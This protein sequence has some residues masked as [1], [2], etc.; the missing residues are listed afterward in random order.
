[1]A[2]AAP[3]QVG[4]KSDSVSNEK[5]KDVR[6][7][8]FIAARAV[9]DAVRTSLGPKGMDK[10]IQTDRSEVIITN[11]G[12][13]ILKKMNVIHPAAKMMVD[14]SK[15]QDAEAGDGTTSVVVLAGALLGAAETLLKKGLHPMQISDGF[16]ASARKAQEILRGMAVPVDLTDREALIRAATTSLNSKL[17]A[18][19]SASLAPLAVDAVLAVLGPDVKTA[20]NLDLRDIRVHARL[21]GTLDDAEIV[22]GLLFSQKIA[23]QA[24]G[25]TRVQNARIGLIQFCLS[26][27]KP[28]MDNQ[29]LVSDYTQIDRILKEERQYIIRQCQ[30]IQKTGCNVLLVQKSI[31]RDAVNDI[32]L[33]MLAKLK[34]LVVTDIERDDIDF[35]C[36]TLGCQPAASIEAFTAERLGRAELVEEVSLPDGKLVR[37]TGVPQPARTVSILLRASNR[38]MLDEAERSLHDA[39]CVLR[40]LVR[41]RFLLPGGAAPEAELALRISEWAKLQP[42]PVQAAARAFAEALET[43]PATLAENAGLSPIQIITELRSRHAAGE[44]HAGLNVRRGHVSNILE[45]HVV[46]PLLVTASVV[47]LATETVCMLLKIDDIVLVR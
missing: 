25:P 6:T 3:L 47:T 45:E 4:K 11:D 34:I 36:R 23:H 30:K 43:V 10:M 31:L 9:A 19:Y 29:V 32:S 12:A 7:S 38:L 18:Q 13:T 21:G 8:N 44:V 33:Q 40:S 41:Q 16:L 35:I 15:S 17:V 5:E 46:Q 39:L 20:S 27:P 26:A 14:M 2:A 1:M 28:N 22:R 24:G 37:I 42:G